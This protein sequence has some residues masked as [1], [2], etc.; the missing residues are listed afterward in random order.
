MYQTLE[1]F[2]INVLTPSIVILTEKTLCNDVNTNQT[3][4]LML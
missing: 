1:Q 4:S 3:F 2:L